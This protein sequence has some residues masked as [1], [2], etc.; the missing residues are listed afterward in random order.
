MLKAAAA[1]WPAA[2]C[3]AGVPIN[4]KSCAVKTAR[5]ALYRIWALA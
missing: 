3:V 4:R 2:A 5:R 1:G